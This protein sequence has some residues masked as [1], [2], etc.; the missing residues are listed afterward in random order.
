MKSLWFVFKESEL[1]LEQLGNDLF[2][3]P[4]SDNPPTFINEGQQVHEMKPTEE[5]IPCK[6]IFGGFF[7]TITPKTRILRTKTVVL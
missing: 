7:N 6:D 5:G 3:I 2:T 4:L 1:L